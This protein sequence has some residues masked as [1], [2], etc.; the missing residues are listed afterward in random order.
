MRSRRVLAANSA[1]CLRYSSQLSPK[2]L[3]SPDR[4]DAMARSMAV[5]SC[6]SFKFHFLYLIYIRQSRLPPIFSSATMARANSGT[7]IYLWKQ[8]FDS[9]VRSRNASAHRQRQTSDKLL[10]WRR[11]TRHCTI[12]L[13]VQR[14]GI[15]GSGKSSR[16]LWQPRR[17]CKCWTDGTL[18]E[19]CC[20]KHPIYEY[21]FIG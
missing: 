9:W 13:F 15:F 20:R 18:G 16:K 14:Y 11:S 2:L 8:L 17:G 1:A 5:C 3:R 7:C 10:N 12:V 21:C 4:S 19:F 6:C